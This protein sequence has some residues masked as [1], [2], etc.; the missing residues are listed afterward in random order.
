MPSSYLDSEDLA[1]KI[2]WEGGAFYFLVYGFAMEELPTDLP[3]DVKN[4]FAVLRDPI[5]LP[6]QRAL[7]RIDAWVEEIY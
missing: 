2:S 4:A 6:F 1:G 3:E 5:H 7:S